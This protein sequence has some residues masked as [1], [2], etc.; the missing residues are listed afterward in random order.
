M[1]VRGSLAGIVLVGLCLQAAPHASA[2]GGLKPVITGVLD[3][4]GAPEAVMVPALDGFVVK[5]DWAS[6]QPTA[7]GP[8]ASG[9]AIDDAVKAI[10]ALGPGADYHVKLRIEAGLYAPAWAKKLGGG[11]VT[12]YKGR[13]ISTFGRFWAPEFGRAYQDLESKLAAKYDD[14]PEIAEVV[15]ARCTIVD[16]EPFLRANRRD[17]RSMRT[18]VAAGF[19]ADA[20]EACHREE[21]DA[22]DVWQ[23]T[24]S[25]LTLNPYDRIQPDGSVVLDEAFTEQM[26][27]YCRTVLG[28]RC[29]LENDSISSPLL[30]KPYPA[31][32]AAIAAL[33]PPIGYQTASPDRIGDWRQTLLW[34]AS[35]GANHVELNTGY[36]TY[37]RTQLADARERLKANPTG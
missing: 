28:A 12:F 32:Y 22:H 36:P 17:V 29:V 7:F 24:R 15:I 33:G 35:Q 13:K 1:A 20:D 6:L 23:R 37:G 8:I 16:A 9:N 11:P 18:L 14:T 3:R 26:M 5:V 21:V 34:A 4:K 19:T 30:A 2:A 31:M 25:G 27:G 10:R